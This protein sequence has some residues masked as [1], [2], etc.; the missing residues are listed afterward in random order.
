MGATLWCLWS[1]DLRRGNFL[2]PQEL[3][4]FNR[5]YVYTIFTSFRETDKKKIYIYK[6]QAE[7]RVDQKTEKIVQ[8]VN[9][10]TLIT[11][12]RIDKNINRYVLFYMSNNTLLTYRY[13]HNIMVEIRKIFLYVRYSTLLAGIPATFGL[14]VT[15]DVKVC[16]LKIITLKGL[17]IDFQK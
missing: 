7:R 8:V 12:C 11:T 14:N 6:K 4:Q 15:A 13:V 10:K 5:N 3:R 9:K 1:M 2:D 16:F 17:I